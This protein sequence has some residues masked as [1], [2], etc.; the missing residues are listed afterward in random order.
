MLRGV[1]LKSLNNI[2]VLY[3]C[4]CRYDLS[5]KMGVE[6][7][8][9]L[10][11]PFHSQVKST[12]CSNNREVFQNQCDECRRCFKMYKDALRKFNSSKPCVHHVNLNV[13]KK[14]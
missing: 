4:I 8:Q 2:D 14:V 13:R 10:M 9:S 5:T 7:F 1:K 12:N 6:M 11:K 3:N